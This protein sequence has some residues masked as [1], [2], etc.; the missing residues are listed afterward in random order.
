VR[1]NKREERSRLN[2]TLWTRANKGEGTLGIT[3]RN[4]VDM[5][6]RKVCTVGWAL[7]CGQLTVERWLINCVCTYIAKD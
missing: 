2:V 4:R 5:K 3:M 7:L 6:M 1:I